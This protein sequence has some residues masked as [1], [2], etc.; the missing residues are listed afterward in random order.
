MHRNKYMRFHK[1]YHDNYFDEL[2]H[3]IINGSKLIG[4]SFK[5]IVGKFSNEAPLLLINM[6]ER[7][8]TFQS[9]FS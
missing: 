7:N 2:W 4:Y 9:F 1:V 5:M 8:K 3:I 6:Y